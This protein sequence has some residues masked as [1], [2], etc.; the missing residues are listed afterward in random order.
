MFLTTREEKNKEKEIK[1]E[2]LPLK[3]HLFIQTLNIPTYRD[4]LSASNYSDYDSLWSF[5]DF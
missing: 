2:Q 5:P 3:D 4:L 1:K